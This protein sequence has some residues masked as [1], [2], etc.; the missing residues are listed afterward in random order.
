MKSAKRFRR[1][2]GEFKLT[3]YYLQEADQAPGTQ[4]SSGGSGSRDSGREPRTQPTQRSSASEK[5]PAAHNKH[6]ARARAGPALTVLNTA[7]GPSGRSKHYLRGRT[8]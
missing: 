6:R 3:T 5:D 1:R 7:W 2:F 8:R 4:Q